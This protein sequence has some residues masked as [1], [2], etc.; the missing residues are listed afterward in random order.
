MTKL[1]EFNNPRS[2]LNK[3]GEQE[4][5]FI[6][7]STDASAPFAIKSWIVAAIAGGVPM[8]KIDGAR[9]L[10]HDMVA[11]QTANPGLVKQPD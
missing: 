6:L 1:E 7:R 11:W 3:A 8:A 10:L 9:Q 5:L 4:P 2:T